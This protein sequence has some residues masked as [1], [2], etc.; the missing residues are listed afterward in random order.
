MADSYV[1][2]GK[3]EGVRYASHG[4]FV[5]V[6]WQVLFRK[7]L[8]YK[9]FAMPQNT[10]PVVG[11]TNNW[12]SHAKTRGCCFYCTNRIAIMESQTAELQVDAD[13]VT[14]LP[15]NGWDEMNL[16]EIPFFV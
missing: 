5:R 1:S 12:A 15:T 3:L 9:P 11:K 7:S 6:S 2:D 8:I 10:K 16:A 4:R 13:L 14:I